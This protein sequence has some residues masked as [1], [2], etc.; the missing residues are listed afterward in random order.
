MGYP[1]INKAMYSDLKKISDELFLPNVELIEHNSITLLET[2]QPFI[3]SYM[4]GINH[5]FARELLWREYPTDQRGSYFRQFWDVSSYL[6]KEGLD[7]K[8]LREKLRDIPP[9][10]RWPR[11]SDL[12]DHDYREQGGEKDEEVVLVIRGE[13]LKKYPTAEIYAHRAKWAVDEHGN[14]KLDEPRD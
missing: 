3:E 4:V 2:N 10:H 7:P 11:A 5:E 12:G 13:L 9:I 8:A 14:R 1:K 6:N